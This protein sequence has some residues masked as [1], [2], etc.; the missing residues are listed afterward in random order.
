MEFLFEVVFNI[1]K[2]GVASEEIS[3]SLCIETAEA[4]ANQRRSP[5]A[6]KHRGAA[7][8]RH[9]FSIINRF[10]SGDVGSQGGTW[11]EVSREVRGKLT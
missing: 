8:S 10:E 3:H 1:F 9:A 7:V 4:Q 5:N 11:G 2:F 6:E